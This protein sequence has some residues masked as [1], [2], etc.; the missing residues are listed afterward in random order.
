MN[1]SSHPEKYLVYSIKV[2]F[3]ESKHPENVEFIDVLH[4]DFFVVKEWDI[5]P[6]NGFFYNEK[7]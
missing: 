1:R 5:Y 4:S 7:N 6:K 3:I 2:V